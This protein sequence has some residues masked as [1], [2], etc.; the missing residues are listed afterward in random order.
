MYARHVCC[1]DGFM[2]PRVLNQ[3][4]LKYV[5]DMDLSKCFDTLGGINRLDHELIL[6]S[7]NRKVSDGSILK[8]IKKFLEAGVMKDGAW[9]ETDIP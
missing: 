4:G 3:Y 2:P 1:A 9:Q 8:L 7:L 5:V 6:E